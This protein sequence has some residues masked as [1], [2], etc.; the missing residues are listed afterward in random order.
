MSFPRYPK[1]K[2][3]GVEWLGEVPEGWGVAPLKTAA[4]HNDD[5]IDDERMALVAF[6]AAGA[7]GAHGTSRNRGDACRRATPAQNSCAFATAKKH[8][9]GARKLS[10]RSAWGAHDGARESRSDARIVLRGAERRE[11]QDASKNHTDDHALILRL[12]VP[13][14]WHVRG[15]S[16]QAARRAPCGTLPNPRQGTRRR[17]PR[18]SRASRSRPPSRGCRRAPGSRSCR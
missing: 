17:Q 10:C 6:N 8:P 9:T 11:G 18:R 16:A 14:P 15:V 5:T 3:S 2:P 4:S 12:R 1:Y 13:S 7:H